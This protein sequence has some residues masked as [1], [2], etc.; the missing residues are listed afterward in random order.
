MWLSSSFPFPDSLHAIYSVPVKDDHVDKPVFHSAGIDLP[1]SDKIIPEFKK[2]WVY[3]PVERST[4]C[5]LTVPLNPSGINAQNMQLIPAGIDISCRVPISR[6]DM[7]VPERF[8]AIAIVSNPKQKKAVVEIVKAPKWA[9]RITWK[10]AT[11]NF[12]YQ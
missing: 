3:I 11:V 9:E 5:I 6:Y 1:M 2:V 8:K 4:E 7:T 10:P 12:I